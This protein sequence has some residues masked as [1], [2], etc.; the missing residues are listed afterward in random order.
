MN[1]TYQFPRKNTSNKHCRTGPDR[2][3]E[4]D[5]NQTSY[6]TKNNDMQQF[7]N[8]NR[9]AGGRYMRHEDF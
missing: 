2:S 4:K 1:N 6:H 7:F 8:N 5:I 3:V 9:V